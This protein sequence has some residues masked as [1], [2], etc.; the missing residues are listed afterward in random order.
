MLVTLWYVKD[1]LLYV[2]IIMQGMFGEVNFTS[3][4]VLPKAVPD[5]SDGHSSF[6]LQLSILIQCTDETAETTVVTN[7]C[8]FRC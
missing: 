7:L 3:S 8:T 6:K 2:C 5:M 4:N 1:S